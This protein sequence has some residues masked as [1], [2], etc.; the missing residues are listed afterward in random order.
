MFNMFKSSDKPYI[1]EYYNYNHGTGKHYLVQEEVDPD[2]PRCSFKCCCDYFVDCFC[3][4][5]A[6]GF[7]VFAGWL[8]YYL[9]NNADSG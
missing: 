4:S 1:S 2:S 3:I 8:C 5:L 9:Y 6:I 7:L